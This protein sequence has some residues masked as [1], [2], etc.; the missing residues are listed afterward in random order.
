MK[1]KRATRDELIAYLQTLPEDVILEV[2]KEH[3]GDW[4]TSVSTVDLI[5]DGDDSNVEFTDLRG[6]RFIKPGQLH[7]NK[8]FLVLGG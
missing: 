8:T 2:L 4:H 3:R 7:Y 6:S 5:L 1:N